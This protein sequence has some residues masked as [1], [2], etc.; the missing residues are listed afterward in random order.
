VNIEKGE[1]KRGKGVGWKY[2]III[3]MQNMAFISIEP[4]N[5]NGKNGATTFSRMTFGR[6][7]L[8]F[9]E[10]HGFGVA[11]LNVVMLSVVILRV[12]I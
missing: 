3:K 11:L 9:V 6:A 4:E 7:T 10:W 1:R 12:I 5:F 8:S 2:E